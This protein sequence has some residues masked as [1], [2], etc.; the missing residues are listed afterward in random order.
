MRPGENEC[1]E[2]MLRLRFDLHGTISEEYLW[3]RDVLGMLG[4]F[5]PSF[6][7]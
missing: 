3:Y 1:L 6:V 4:V 2:T 5:L 7:R